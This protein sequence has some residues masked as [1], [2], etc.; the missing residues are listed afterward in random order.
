MKFCTSC[1]AQLNEQA[2]FCTS[3]GTKVT[4]NVSTQ[5]SPVPQQQA[6]PLQQGYIQPQPPVYTQQPQPTASPPT[7]QQ[8]VYMPTSPVQQP[9]YQ[10]NIPQPYQQQTQPKQQVLYNAPYAL[11]RPDQPWSVTIEGENIVARWN[12]MDGRF[13]SPHEVTNVTRDYTFTVSLLDNY[14]WKEIDTTTNKK[15]G[16]NMSGG[17]IGFGSSSNTFK[18]KTSQ[19]SFSAGIGQNNT[20]EV[21][22]V[23]FK[24]DTNAVKQPIRSYLSSCG[25]RK[26]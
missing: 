2:V 11:N 5:A 7:P 4:G 1:G 15:S 9:Q 26:A 20:G 18:G 10:Q 23:T 6:V 19:K 12:W 17:K 16:I 22:I 8:Q 21:G 13:F 14:T 3:C 25:W 24:F